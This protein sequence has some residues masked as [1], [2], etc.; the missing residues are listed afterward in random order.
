MLFRSIVEDDP[1]S[2]RPI[3]S[4]NDQ[5]VEVV[6]AMMARDCRLSVLMIAEETA[7]NKNADHKILTEHLHMRKFC[8]KLVPKNLSVEQKANLLEICQ[9]FLGT[10]DIEPFLHK[11]IT[12]DESWV[13]DYDPETKLQSEEWH[14]KSS[15]LPKKAR[16]S[17]SRVKKNDYWLST[18]VALCTKNLYVQDR[19]LI[20]PSTKMSWNDFENGSSESEG[21]LQTIGCCNTITRHLTLRFHF[22]NFWRRETFPYFHIPPTAQI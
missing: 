12:G 18:A 6:R 16:M 1:R 2:G 9:D 8:A 21:T 22:E 20:T 15:P 19:H 10:L 4:T 5:N 11:V 14:T 17:K 13:F 3:S 7:L